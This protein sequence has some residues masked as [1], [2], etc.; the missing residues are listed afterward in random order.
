[1]I[2]LISPPLDFVALSEGMGVPAIRA[3]TI[4]ELAA[5]SQPLYPHRDRT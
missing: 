5:S 3:E 4:A 1:M 2:D